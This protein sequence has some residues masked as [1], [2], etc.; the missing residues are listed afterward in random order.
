MGRHHRARLTGTI[1]IAAAAAWLTN[2]AYLLIT[3]SAA[4]VGSTTWYAGQ[5]LSAPAVLGTTIIIGGLWWTR[6][7]GAGRFA[8]LIL[9]AWTIGFLLVFA[10]TVISI[11]TA[12]PANPLLPLGGMLASVAGVAGGIVILRPRSLMPGGAGPHLLSRSGT[13]WSSAASWPSPSTAGWPPP[14]N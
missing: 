11:A 7:G 5:A 8:R 4:T 1:G 14:R 13:A 3:D 10:G 6:A 9:G 2:W 12:N